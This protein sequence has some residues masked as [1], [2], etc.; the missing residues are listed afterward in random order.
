MLR[1]LTGRLSLKV[2]ARARLL[3]SKPA[4]AETGGN[5]MDHL[6]VLFLY[7]IPAI[8]FIIN[9]PLRYDSHFFQ[10]SG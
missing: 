5:I 9:Y 1:S 2:T 3:V 6:K 10:K 4:F 8:S 7:N